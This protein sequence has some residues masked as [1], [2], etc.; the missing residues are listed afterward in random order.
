MEF[1]GQNAQ[2]ASSEP[3]GHVTL[4]SL[5]RKSGAIWLWMLGGAWLVSGSAWLVSGRAWL[6]SGSAW[7]VSGMGFCQVA[8]G[9]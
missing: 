7:L 8:N 5:G 6:V 2:K 3:R 4:F 9:L 1:E